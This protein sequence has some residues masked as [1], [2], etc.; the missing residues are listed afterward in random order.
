VIITA[1]IGG[2]QIFAEPRLY[3]DPMAVNPGGNFRQY[4]TA[5]L[6]IWDMAFLRQNFGRAS[7]I[8]ILLFFIIVSVALINFIIA[9][10]LAITRDL[11]PNRPKRPLIGVK[12]LSV[13]S[14]VSRNEKELASAGTGGQA[15]SRGENLGARS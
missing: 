14:R 10:R 2:M 6:Y 8:A 4:E 7:A 11:R 12:P 9:T 5:V 1:T 13:G 3:S 15:D